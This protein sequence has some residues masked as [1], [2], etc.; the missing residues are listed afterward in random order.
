MCEVVGSGGGSGGVAVSF[1]IAH[2]QL[3][4]ASA[5]HRPEW[6]EAGKPVPAKLDVLARMEQFY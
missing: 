2:S 5:V 6:A 1:A 3:H 4:T